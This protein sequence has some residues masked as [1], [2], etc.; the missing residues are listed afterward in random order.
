MR[1]RGR[2]KASSS[3]EELRP[4]ERRACVG[5]RHADEDVGERG[6]PLLRVL[7]VLKRRREGSVDL[8]RRRSKCWDG[9]APLLEC[10]TTAGEVALSGAETANFHSPLEPAVSVWTRQRLMPGARGLVEILTTSYRVRS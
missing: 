4:R 3:R 1:G 10:T 8:L 9:S 6:E 5:M 2:K 7:L